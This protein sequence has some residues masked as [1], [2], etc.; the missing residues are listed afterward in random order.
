MYIL[1][2][3]CVGS[4]QMMLDHHTARESMFAQLVENIV[5]NSFRLNSVPCLVFKASIAFYH[6]IFYNHVIDILLSLCPLSSAL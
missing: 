6:I 3:M 4:L 2:A 5:N 1:H